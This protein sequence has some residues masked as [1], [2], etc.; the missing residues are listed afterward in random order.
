MKYLIGLCLSVL[1]MASCK[2]T[3]IRDVVRFVAEKQVDTTGYSRRT[4]HVDTFMA[5]NIRGLADVT[6]HQ[7][8]T[9]ELPRV[10]LAAPTAQLLDWVKV[11]VDE[12]ATLTVST[13]EENSQ[14]ANHMVV[15]HLYS[16]SVSHFALEGGKCLRLMQMKASVPV[17]IEL[18]G[19]G[20]VS[21]DRLVAPRVDASLHGAGC[22]SLGGLHT[23]DLKANLEGTGSIVLEGKA[24]KASIEADGIGIIDTDNLITP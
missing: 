18:V 21:C 19:L 10:E 16:P 20:L 5:V 9:Y 1:C 15:V 3:N 6:Y 13:A 4:V 22:I 11:A 14:Q 23:N 12:D 17:Q 24:A 2:H 8:P 7:T